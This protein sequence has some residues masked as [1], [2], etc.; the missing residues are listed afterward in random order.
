MKVQLAA[1]RLLALVLI[2]AGIAATTSPLDEIQNNFHALSDLSSAYELI[3]AT[4]FQAMCNV[5]RQVRSNVCNETDS[6]D[7]IRNVTCS[8]VSGMPGIS[9]TFTCQQVVDVLCVIE[10][11]RILPYHTTLTRCGTFK[12]IQLLTLS[13]RATL[14]NG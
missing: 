13:R 12:F 3:D 7:E 2:H 5:L 1:A 9:A 8:Y 10:E 14:A 4:K 11:I 6:L